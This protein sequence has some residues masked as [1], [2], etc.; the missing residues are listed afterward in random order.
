MFSPFSLEFYINY[1][2]SIEIQGLSS[3][4]CNFQG[5]SR[6]LSRCVQG[7]ILYHMQVTIIFVN[8]KSATLF[9]HDSKQN[10]L[11]QF[12]KQSVHKRKLRG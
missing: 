5:F 11:L 12:S 10:K 8:G 2:V 1:K 3:T 9:G 4:D 6:Q 7:L